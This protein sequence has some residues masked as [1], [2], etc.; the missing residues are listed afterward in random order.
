M[1]HKTFN[2]ERGKVW[3]VSNVSAVVCAFLCTFVC[4]REEPNVQ[5]G[6]DRQI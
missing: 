4:K 1:K 2:K 3:C 6:A 5:R